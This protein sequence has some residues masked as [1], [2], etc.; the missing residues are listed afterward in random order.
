MRKN[1][2]C[3]SDVIFAAHDFCFTGIITRVSLIGEDTNG[4]L[5]TI[6]QQYKYLNKVKHDSFY[7]FNQSKSWVY[8]QGHFDDKD[9]QEYVA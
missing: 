8:I 2:L 6:E 7:L 4:L 3:F 9:T 5:D 1:P